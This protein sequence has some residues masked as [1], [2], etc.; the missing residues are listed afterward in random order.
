M[1][2]KSICSCGSDLV[3][4]GS[5]VISYDR[6]LMRTNRALNRLVPK[7]SDPTECHQTGKKLVA[8]SP[9][10]SLNIHLPQKFHQQIY[11]YHL[12]NFNQLPTPFNH[13][14][15]TSKFPNFSLGFTWFHHGTAGSHRFG[16]PRATADPGSLP[17]PGEPPAPGHHATAPH[18]AQRAEETPQLGAGGAGAA[19]LGTKQGKN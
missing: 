14:S 13:I 8:I 19:L 15:K 6:T 18:P 10:K 3:A 17:Q 4:L 2:D 12:F 9:A 7:T 1:A 11:Q 16:S 5:K